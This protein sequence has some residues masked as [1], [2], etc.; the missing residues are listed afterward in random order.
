M[1][2]SSDEFNDILEDI[3]LYIS[4]LIDE[5]MITPNQALPFYK[6]KDKLEELSEKVFRFKMRN[7]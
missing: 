6:A 3:E 5:D 2:D 7:K 1:I 4:N